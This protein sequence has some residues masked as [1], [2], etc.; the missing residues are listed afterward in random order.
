MF[1]CVAVNAQGQQIY[2]DA[3]DAFNQSK[4]RLATSL[5]DQA[6]IEYE[7]GSEKEIQLTRNC[8]KLQATARQVHKDGNLELAS[9]YFEQ[10]LKLN[11][12]DQEAKEF[13]AKYGATKPKIEKLQD[14]PDEYFTPP[15]ACHGKRLE[16]YINKRLVEMSYKE[17]VDYCNLLNMNGAATWRLPSMGEYVSLI[18]DFS[19]LKGTYIWVNSEDIM[20]GNQTIEEFEATH[21]RKCC[22]SFDGE[23][24]EFRPYYVNSRGECVS[25]TV[26]KLWF[27]PV[28]VL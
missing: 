28:R 10:L 15:I 26:Q 23:Y 13:L 14:L 4:Y 2:K 17:A 1:V 3:K 20:A 8:D 6:F 25:G 5:F 9:L 12:N 21:A 16:F 7:L 11:P 27:I 24:M 19:E 22:P 18:N